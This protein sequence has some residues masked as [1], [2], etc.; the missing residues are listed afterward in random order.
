MSSAPKGRRPRSQLGEGD[1][2][3]R[4][5]ISKRIGMDRGTLAKYLA[6]EGAPG[7]DAAHRYSLA[8]V[9]A[10]F[11]ANSPKSNTAEMR[12][13]KEAQAR[14]ELEKSKL[15]LDIMKNRYHL[16]SDI[17]PGIEAVMSR[18]SADLVSV[19]EGELPPKCAGKTTNEIRE[20]M[21]AAVDRVM[22]R[23]KEGWGQIA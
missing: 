2:L 1:K 19:F 17:R 20:L 23:M 9:K 6:M 11:D 5:Q 21:A 10:W 4:T 3:T 14:L 22:R 12:T 16:K 8:A 7:P 15:E 13:L 18:H